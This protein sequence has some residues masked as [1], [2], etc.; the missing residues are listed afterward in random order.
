MDTAWSQYNLNVLKRGRQDSD[1]HGG[2][3]M[4]DTEAGVMG[5]GMQSGDTGSS[6]SWKSKETDSPLNAVLLTPRF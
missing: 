1:S 2:E 4:M 3:V 6:G 5:E